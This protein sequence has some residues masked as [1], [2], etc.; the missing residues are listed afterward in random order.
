[1]DD[2]ISVGEVLRSISEIEGAGKIVG[3]LINTEKWRE[4]KTRKERFS[5]AHP[6]TVQFDT[7]RGATT[8]ARNFYR[9][10]DRVDGGGR[11]TLKLEFSNREMDASVKTLMCAGL[12]VGIGKEIDFF[13]QP[14]FIHKGTNEEYDIV[15][16]PALE[17]SVNRE[18]C[19]RN[20]GGG[21]GEED[22]EYDN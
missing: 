10:Y 4:P 20:F 21:I 9:E 12:R 15:N 3:V 1:M 6:V 19:I 16:Q 2:S 13:L 14:W 5:I 7:G 11:R 22:W 18:G 8:A 17:W